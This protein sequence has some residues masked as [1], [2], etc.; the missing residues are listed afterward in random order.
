MHPHQWERFG[1]LAG[2]SKVRVDEQWSTLGP[3][4]WAEV[5]VAGPHAWWNDTPALLSPNRATPT[6]KLGG[7][8]LG[9]GRT[10]RVTCPD[11]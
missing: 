7:A 10:A 6:R 9:P 3:G 8:L 5:P 11:G 4:E 1:V 2:T